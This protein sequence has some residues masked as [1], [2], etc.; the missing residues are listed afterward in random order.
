MYGARW[1]H[2]YDLKRRRIDPTPADALRMH[3]LERPESWEQALLDK[4][5]IPDADIMQQYPDYVP[6][7]ER[8]AAT[9]GVPAE[10]MVIGQ[11]VEGL[12]RDLIMLTCEPGDR[13]IYTHPT[14]AMFGLY[15]QM[16]GAIQARVPT[17][18]ANPPTI[19]DLISAL[20]KT[21]RARLMLLPNPGQPVETNFTPVE[22]GQLAEACFHR[23]VVLAVDEAYFGFGAHTAVKLALTCPNVVVLRS[24]SKAFGAASLRV[25]FA[26]GSQ[27]AVHPL[28]AVRQSGE[29][30]GPSLRRVM[31]L[32]DNPDL[33]LAGIADVVRGR[34]WLRTALAAA[35]VTSYGDWANHVLIDMDTPHRAREVHRLLWGASIR[36]RHFDDAPLDR[37]LMVT[38]GSLA[39]MR[40]FYTAFT[41]AVRVH[42][43]A[44]EVG[45]A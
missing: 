30:S 19:A 38:C 35:G 20:N 43:V 40:K 41:A 27:L 2:L 45:H 36:V 14:C 6:L 33:V 7:Y 12:V 5:N 10:S 32:L 3:R 42:D 17:D 22:L 28:D 37:H 11:G 18:P 4:L 29:I 39:L 44:R 8:L 34:V 23:G 24:F 26:V 31:V 16:F 1:Q 13:V 21:P 15:A 25:G 9:V